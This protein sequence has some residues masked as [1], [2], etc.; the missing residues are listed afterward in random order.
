M[1]QLLETACNSRLE[2]IRSVRASDVVATALA[3]ANGTFS[4]EQFREWILA[5]F[6]SV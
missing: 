1:L 5:N 2:R 3:V 6:E 4:Y